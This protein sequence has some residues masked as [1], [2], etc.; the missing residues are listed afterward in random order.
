[1]ISDTQKEV[2][3]GGWIA[4]Y[5]IVF[6]AFRSLRLVWLFR[7]LIDVSDYDAENTGT[8]SSVQVNRVNR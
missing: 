4:E 5:L 1:M 3:W 6:G 8:N 2:G 7:L